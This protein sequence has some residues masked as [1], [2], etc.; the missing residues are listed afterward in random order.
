M[1]EDQND[2]LNDEIDEVAQ[3]ADLEPKMA[4][5]EFCAS[6][7]EVLENSDDEMSGFLGFAI[8][9]EGVIRMSVKGQ[10]H[11]CLGLLEHARYRI[12]E[13]LDA[14]IEVL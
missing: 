7:N 14:D 6:V 3:Q 9:R 8:S 10:A 11:L 1:A 5:F 13:Q 12:L 4:Y 2:E